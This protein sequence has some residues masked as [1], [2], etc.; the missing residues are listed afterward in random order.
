[1][2]KHIFVCGNSFSNGMYVE[3]ENMR[4][5]Y[6]YDDMILKYHRPWIE[7]IAEELDIEYTSLARPIASNYYVCKQI[8]YAIKQK[9][10]LVIASFSSVRHI[11]FTTKDKR[12]TSLPTLEN[13]VYNE[14]TFAKGYTNPTNSSEEEQSVQCL[15]YPNLERYAQTTNPEY[16]TV[17]EYIRQFND[18]L[19]KMDQE[20]LMILGAIEQLHMSNTKFLIVDL[21]SRTDNMDRIKDPKT[22]ADTNVMNI[23][24]VDPYISLPL[25]FRKQYPNPTDDFHFN[26]E[27]NIAAAKLFIPKIKELLGL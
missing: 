1:M 26:Q 10:D 8:E 13:L 23:V 18:Y 25:D 24:D 2:K 6:D 7:F 9:P 17:V 3:K 22:L 21:I 16:K 27:G 14:K 12:L 5:E 4:G 20:K 19:L 15:R 11:D